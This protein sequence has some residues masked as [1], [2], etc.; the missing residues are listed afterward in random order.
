LH[1]A[2][3]RCAILKRAAKCDEIPADLNSITLVQ[4]SAFSTRLDLER[5]DT[6][7]KTADLFEQVVWLTTQA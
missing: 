5:S 3:V 1:I 6:P 2:D 7:A 4:T